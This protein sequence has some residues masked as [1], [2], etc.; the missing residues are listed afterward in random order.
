MEITQAFVILSLW[1]G[2]ALLPFLPAQRRPRASEVERGDAAAVPKEAP[3]EHVG[4][5]RQSSPAQPSRSQDV[6][7]IIQAQTNMITA[8]FRGATSLTKELTFWKLVGIA[9]V[10][11]ALERV[12]EATHMR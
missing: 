5:E 2:P 6:V 9:L 7:L 4:V 1:I 12:V 11:L 8:T 3:R 10:L